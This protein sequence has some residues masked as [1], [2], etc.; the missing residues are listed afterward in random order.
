LEGYESDAAREGIMNEHE[1]DDRS[2]SQ[3]KELPVLDPV[4]RVEKRR[5]GDLVVDLSGI[6]ELNLASLALLL[7]AQQNAKEEDRAVWLAGVPLNVWQALD[8]MGL[9]RFFKPFPVSG[10]VAV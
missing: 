2:E 3:A 8:A 7:T 4:D 9:G 6:K 5:K 1:K 10:E